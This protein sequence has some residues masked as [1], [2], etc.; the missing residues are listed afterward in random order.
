VITIG[1][2]WYTAWVN[3]GMPDLNK[4]VSKANISEGF[5]PE[6]GSGKADSLRI[7]DH[8]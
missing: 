8:E 5:D 3:A 6:L 1:S 4:F 7:R 2:Y